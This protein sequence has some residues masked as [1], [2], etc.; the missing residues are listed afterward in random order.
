[1]I[2]RRY[3]YAATGCVVLVISI[4]TLVLRH[5]YQQQLA[6]WHERLTRTVDAKQQVLEHWVTER[7][8][9]NSDAETRFHMACLFRETRKII[10]SSDWP[11]HA[12]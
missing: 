3:L 12:L 9:V 10:D 1:M 7:D 5:E 6:Y 8:Q 11:G 2:T 4:T